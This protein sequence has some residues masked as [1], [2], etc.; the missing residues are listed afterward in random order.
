MSGHFEECEEWEWGGRGGGEEEG[1][2]GRG[3]GGCL[4]AVSL[5]HTLFP[6]GVQ[7]V[8]RRR[9]KAIDI[10]K[11]FVCVRVFCVCVCV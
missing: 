2:G 9:L 8:R 4:H 11:V 1:G 10:F 7:P 6:G 5:Q 3:E